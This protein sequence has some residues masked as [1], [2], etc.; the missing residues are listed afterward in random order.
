MVTAGEAMSARSARAIDEQK[1]I[2]QARTLKF[3][4]LQVELTSK[5]TYIG[6]II[7]LA[8]GILS[9]KLS[10]GV[11]SVT[12]DSLQYANENVLLLGNSLKGTLLALCYP[13]TLLNINKA[14]WISG[15]IIGCSSHK[16]G[17]SRS[18]RVG[19]VIWQSQPVGDRK[20]FCLVSSPDSREFKWLFKYS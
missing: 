17:T 3:G 6:S 8:F 1:P 4:S 15:Y 11:Q 5:Q 9:W 18:L 2:D 20:A 12:K 16:R 10:T 7:A 19:F 14:Y 13:C